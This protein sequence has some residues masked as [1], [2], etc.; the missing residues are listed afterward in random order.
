MILQHPLTPPRNSPYLPIASTAYCE[1][2]GVNRHEAGSKG[3]TCLLYTLTTAM[4]A[5]PSTYRTRHFLSKSD[6]Q[7]SSKLYQT[8]YP[9]HGNR[10]RRPRDGQI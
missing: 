5:L 7:A 10:L 9:D 1:Q 3:E 2:L 6:L 4:I 8:P